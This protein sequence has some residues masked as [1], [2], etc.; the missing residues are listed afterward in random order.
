MR[1]VLL[2]HG[3]LGFSKIGPISYFNGVDAYWN[4]KPNFLRPAV[5]PAGTIQSRAQE[6]KAAIEAAFS[7]D[8]L[9]KGKVVHIVA[10][11]MGGLD[12]RYLISPAGLNCANWVRSLTTLSTPHL[13]SPLAD[14]VIGKRHLTL[15]EVTH[16]V[17]SVNHEIL[18]SILRAM[19]KPVPSNPLLPALNLPE[20]FDAFKDV[21]SYLR[22]LFDVP[23]K[24]FEELST[25]FV[26]AFTQN[27][28]DLQGVPFL[29]FAGNSAPSVSMCRLFY[30]PWLILK[31]IAGDNDGAVPVTSSSLGSDVRTVPADH[32]EEVGVANL[33]DGVPPIAHFEICKL[34]QQ[35]DAW[36]R[37]I[38]GV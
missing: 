31:G 13:G 9:K 35:I 2:A 27:H 23:P 21:G 37:S 4:P 1:T 36:Q 29:C 17:G 3:V 19:G 5:D 25:D 16:L 12:A 7:A 28:S 32:F 14:I 22:G 8:D 24:A 15:A 30:G 33:F 38:D 18:E 26:T 11:S 34:Y 20:L 10:H 6:L